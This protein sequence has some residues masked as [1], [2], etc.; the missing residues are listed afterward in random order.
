M[1]PTPGNPSGLFTCLGSEGPSLVSFQNIDRLPP[2][3]LIGFF[4]Q[5]PSQLLAHGTLNH[6]P[7]KK[8]INL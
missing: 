8:K 4:Q 6:R 2:W 3:V 7:R 1:H 5:G